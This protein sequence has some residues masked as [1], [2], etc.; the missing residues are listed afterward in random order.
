MA[1]LISIDNEKIEVDNDLINKSEVWK[2][3]L[4]FGGIETSTKYIKVDLPS[5]SLIYIIDLLETEPFDFDNI[6]NKIKNLSLGQLATVRDYTDKYMINELKDYV[7]KTI[8]IVINK[9]ISFYR[10]KYYFITT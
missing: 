3:T 8:A 9:K 6:F 7:D 5:N 4:T 10:T 1:V 2:K